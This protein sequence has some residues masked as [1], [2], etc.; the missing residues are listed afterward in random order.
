MEG[1]GGHTKECKVRTTTSAN[2]LLAAAPPFPRFIRPRPRQPAPPPPAVVVVVVVVVSTSFFI[3]SFLHCR[4]LQRI[5]IQ[6]ALSSPSLNCFPHPFLFLIPLS[7]SPPA[8][9]PPPSRPHP[10][11][12]RGSTA[13]AAI[14]RARVPLDA[15]RSPAETTKRRGKS[16]SLCFR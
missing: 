10:L 13:L 3:V 11:G 5:I 7:A 1:S 8:P 15:Q 6:G 2:P 12:R 4:R 14:P 9:A 16:V